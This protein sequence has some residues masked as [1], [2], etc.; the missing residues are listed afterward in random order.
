MCSP[1]TSTEQEHRLLTCVGVMM[2]TPPTMSVLYDTC[3]LPQSPWRLRLS[4]AGCVSD[5]FGTWK[6][7]ID[8][9]IKSAIKSV[10]AT[11]PISRGLSPSFR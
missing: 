10:F 1:E 3:F 5:C 9:S 4:E 8:Y 7:E 6:S 11:L 2:G